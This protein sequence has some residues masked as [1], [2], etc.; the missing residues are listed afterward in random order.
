MLAALSRPEAA[1]GF[2]R[3]LVVQHGRLVDDGAY[4]ALS[5]ADGPLAPLMAAE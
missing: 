4:E 1:R 3:V 5:R 2:E